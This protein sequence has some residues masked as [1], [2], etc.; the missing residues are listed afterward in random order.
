MPRQVLL[1]RP[2]RALAAAFRC[3]TGR[4]RHRRPLPAAG[5][6]QPDGRPT[7]P[8]LQSLLVRRSRR[9]PAV[10][11]R[12]DLRCARPVADRDSSPACG[13]PGGCSPR[14]VPCS[15]AW[16]C[17]SRSHGSLDHEAHATSTESAR[18]LAG[19]DLEARSRVQGPPEVGEVS[20]ALDAL[21]SRIGDLAPRRAR[22]RRRP[23]SQPQMSPRRCGWT[24]SCSTTRSR[25][26]G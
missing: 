7:R 26:D 5:R 11:A 19:G 21:A 10:L 16:Q 15:S 8:R 2:M 12:R 13:S 18:R 9:L 22:T 17:W 23:L 6:R 14:W 4:R 20:R 3:T 24:R 25:Q 1:H